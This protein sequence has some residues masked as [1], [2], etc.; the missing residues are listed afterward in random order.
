MITLLV[1]GT[2]CTSQAQDE[3]SKIKVKITKE[4][5]GKK[6]TFE[7]EYANGEEMRSDEEYREF[8]GDADDFAFHFDMDGMH[9]KMIELHEDGGARAFSF[10]FDDDDFPKKHM[11]R[12]Q[13]HGGGQNAFWFGDDDAV[14]DMR[15][16]GFED[17][18]EELEEKMEELEEKLKGLDKSLREDIMESL[19]EIQE[20]NSG[21]FPRRIKRGGISIQDTGDDFGKRGKVEEKNK[22]DADDMNFMIMNKRLTL[23]FGV[24]EAGELSVKISKEDGK[25]IYNRYFEKFGGMFSDHIDFSEYSEGNYLLE[26]AKDKKRLTKKIVID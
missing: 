23:R 6:M 5:D 1:A 9:E 7:K 24:K 16:I 4:V 20:M 15:G 11:K 25:E 10:S 14:I 22:L 18:E 26:I 19:E 21:I 13:L 8:A 17:Y 2:A 3:D 12:L